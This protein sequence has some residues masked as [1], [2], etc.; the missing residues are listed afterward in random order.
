M[1]ALGELRLLDALFQRVRRTNSA[2][3][4]FNGHKMDSRRLAVRTRQDGR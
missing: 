2:F 4:L 1:L 3:F